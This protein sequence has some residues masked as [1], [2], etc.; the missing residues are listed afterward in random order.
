MIPCS[1]E[2]PYS[3]IFVV[4]VMVKNNIHDKSMRPVKSH[5][6]AGIFGF[7]ITAEAKNMMRRF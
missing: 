7:T 2:I 1:N 6:I 5:I 3:R 4:T